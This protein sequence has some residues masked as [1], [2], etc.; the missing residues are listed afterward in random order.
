MFLFIR[1]FV[2]RTLF[3][4][5]TRLAEAL[6]K[7][8]FE[9]RI[10]YEMI[11]LVQYGIYRTLITVGILVAILFTQSRSAM[12]A[13]GAVLFVLFLHLAKRYIGILGMLLVVVLTVILSYFSMLYIQRNS[14]WDNRGVIWQEGLKLIWERPIIGYGQE[15]FGNAFP[16]KLL[17]NVDNTHNIFLETVVSSGIVG[18]LLFSAI[19]VYGVWK[20]SYPVKASLVVFVI[21]AQFNPLSL[22]HISLFWFLLGLSGGSKLPS[23]SKL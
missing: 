1:K 8:V 9:F 10:F 22:V 3:R 11:K 14:I 6:T 19:L 23:S 20:A 16:K 17:F 2:F 4:V 18:L 15:N 7:R 13:G 21:I 12:I 5:S